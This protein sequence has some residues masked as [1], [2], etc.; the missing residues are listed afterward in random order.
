[1]GNVRFAGVYLLLVLVSCQSFKATFGDLK[2]SPEETGSTIFHIKNGSLKVEDA[3]RRPLDAFQLVLDG[4]PYVLR[5]D[6]I[7]NPYA[8]LQSELRYYSRLIVDLGNGLTLDAYGNLCLD[9]VRL[10]GLSDS[11]K[12]RIARKPLFG[13]PADSGSWEKDGQQFIVKLPQGE[14]NT[15]SWTDDRLEIVPHNQFGVPNTI[16]RKRPEGLFLS[17]GLDAKQSQQ[18][19]LRS[20]TEAAWF[21]EQ[22]ENHLIAIGDTVE[23]SDTLRAGQSVALSTLRLVNA[24]DRL[25]IY[26]QSSAMGT[27]VSGKHTFLKTAT[28]AQFFSTNGASFQ[29]IEIRRK[30]NVIQVLEGQDLLEEYEIQDV[31]P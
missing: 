15:G 24:E 18:L 12:F 23:F 19:L 31:E 5:V 25:Q 27:T 6:L 17:R 28:G 14:S 3:A 29:G 2:D 16:I 21:S 30:G 1:M 22:D 4:D 8:R 9:I 11:R 7:R 13:N 26:D 10:Y 20:D